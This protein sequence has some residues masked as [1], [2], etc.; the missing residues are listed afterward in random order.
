MPPGT[1]Q[2]P[3]GKPAMPRDV[4]C[5]GPSRKAGQAAVATHVANTLGMKYFCTL[6]IPENFFLSG[7]CKSQGAI[8]SEGGKFAWSK[9]K[10][11]RH[12]VWCTAGN[13]GGVCRLEKC[14]EILLGRGF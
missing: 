4:E 9:E 7:T 6:T 2:M 11:L 5:P 14:L 13:T 3:R 8:L 1:R 10:V 12:L